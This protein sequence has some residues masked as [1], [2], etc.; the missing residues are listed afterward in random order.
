MEKKEICDYLEKGLGLFPLRTEILNNK[1]TIQDL[2]SQIQSLQMMDKT[3]NYELSIL[4]P[5]IMRLKEKKSLEEEKEHLEKERTWLNRTKI[6]EEIK[7][8]RDEIS[9]FEKNAAR[10]EEERK[11]I[12]STIEQLEDSIKESNANIS[13]LSQTILDEKVKEKNLDVEIDRWQ[14]DKDNYGNKILRAKSKIKL[15]NAEE[16]RLTED[17]KIV[18]AEIKKYKFELSILNQQRKSIMDEFNSHQKTRKKHQHIMAQ[19]EK[20]KKEKNEIELKAKENQLEIDSIDKEVKKCMNDIRYLR[21]ELEKDKWYLKDPQKN[22]ME[23][24]TQKRRKINYA[25]EKLTN[26][27]AELDKKNSGLDKEVEQLKSSVLMKELPKSQAILDLMREIKSRDLDVIGPI[28]DYIDFKSEITLAVDSILNKYVLNSFI[29]KNKQDFLLIHDLIKRTG[30]RC[31]VYQPFS[32][33]IRNYKTINKEEGV[34]G[35]LVDFITPI[36]NHDEIK[37]VILSICRNTVLV[38]DRSIGYDFINKNNHR[39]RVVAIDGT[40]IRS[41]EYALE[42]RASETRKTYSN[43]IEQKREVKRIQSEL[44]ENRQKIEEYRQQKIKLEKALDLLQDRLQKISSITFNYKNMTITINKKDHLLQKKAKLT[45]ERSVY[46]SELNT[47]Q[48]EIDSVQK[49]FPENFDEMD[50]FIDEFQDN[51]KELDSK[52]EVMNANL[53]NKAKEESRISLSLE[54]YMEDLENQIKKLENLEDELKSGNERLLDAINALGKVRDKIDKLSKEQ[55]ELSNNV[56]KVQET[57]QTEQNSLNSVTQSIDRLSIKI[58]FANAQIFD[59]QKLVDNITIEITELGENYVER[60]IEEVENDL[61]VVYEKLREYYDVTDQVLERKR[62]LENQITRT[63]QKKSELEKEAKEAKKS[64]NALQDQYFSSFKRHLVTIQNKINTRFDKIGINRNGLLSFTG[65]FENLGVDIDVQFEDTTR[66]LSSLSGGEQTLFAI[67]LMLTLQ[68]L[69]PSPL[70]I[71]DEAQM[72]LD[73]SNTESVSKLIKDVT[74]SGVQFIMIT[75]NAANSLLELA[76]SV[77]GIAK[78]GSEE[79]STVISL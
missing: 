52:I 57:V 38:N 71:F 42:S 78:N 3:A 72:F 53:T 59:K 54:K 6:E 68:N 48:D 41:Y 55:Q 70:C 44:N 31:N 40:V 66:K 63:A 28:I 67:S 74:E 51:I 69:N 10:L 65:E 62:E 2:E 12:T 35:Y 60:T 16:K 25:L 49:K 56:L 9:N 77:L 26:N 13:A 4:A 23:S 5:Q 45:E 73:K 21:Q 27:I 64:A 15:L 14:S 39:G 61:R 32:K 43:P 7:Q 24:L 47:V 29:A 22:S 36:S 33:N 11:K 75:P 18:Q 34:F 1:A 17:Q 8:I 37:K 46:S 30:A 58:D 79:V 20:L 76:D 50:K 19:Y